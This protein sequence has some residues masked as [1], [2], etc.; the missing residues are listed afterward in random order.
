MVA[1]NKFLSSVLLAIAYASFASAFQARD[2]PKHTHRVRHISR[3]LKLE[4]FHPESTYEVCLLCLSFTQPVAEGP[5]TARPSDP[6]WPLISTSIP[7]HQR[8]STRLLL[9]LFSPVSALTPTRSD[10]GAD[11][12]TGTKSMP[13]LGSTMWVSFEMLSVTITY[14]K[15]PYNRRVFRSSTPLQT[16]PGRTTRWSPSVLHS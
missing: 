10:T 16:L 15:Y 12:P 14:P 11:M 4:T 9:P 5:C 2:L 7:E 13:M 3:E 8:I 6:D 1:T